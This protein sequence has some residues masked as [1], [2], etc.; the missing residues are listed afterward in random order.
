MASESDLV[1]GTISE[2]MG[3]ISALM[4]AVTIGGFMIYARAVIIKSR[5]V[6]YSMAACSAGGL[7]VFQAALHI[8]GILGILP[9]TGVTLPFVSYGGSSMMACWGLLAFIKSADERTYY[10]KGTAEKPKRGE[11]L[12]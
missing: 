4:L 9:L 6:F 10:K 3:L 2:E 11:V 8:F 1:F 12:I 7:L 5:S